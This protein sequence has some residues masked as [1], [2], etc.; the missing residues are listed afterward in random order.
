[1]GYWGNLEHGRLL[2]DE[3]FGF[4]GVDH[5]LGSAE[6]DGMIGHTGGTGG[7]GK[8]RTPRIPIGRSLAAAHR[9]HRRAYPQPIGPH[10][11]KEVKLAVLL[12][13][14]IL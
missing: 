8:R 13:N 9:W 3:V 14:Q 11:L 6:M 10:G 12:G 1:M 5:H 4:I 2:E 7:V